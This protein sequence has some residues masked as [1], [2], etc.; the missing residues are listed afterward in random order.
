MKTFLVIV[1]VLG[2]GTEPAPPT[3]TKEE[4]YRAYANLVGKWETKG[5]WAN[6]SDFHQ[7]IVVETE[8][9]EN[10][11]IVKTHDYV[12]SKQ[13]DNARRNYGIRAW[14]KDEQKMKFWEFD[15]FGGIISGEV[16]IDGLDMY[17]VYEY[18]MKDG[19]KQ[20]LADAWI[21]VDKDTYAYKICAFE[22]GKAGK[23][24]MSATY[25]RK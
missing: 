3:L 14:D 22:G 19:S 13:F 18:Q 16:I 11:F 12:D 24:Y 8:L 17:H 9:T 25:K 10:I 5:K 7:E 6:G 15:V 2:L 1:A 21:F 4:A 20:T 23:E